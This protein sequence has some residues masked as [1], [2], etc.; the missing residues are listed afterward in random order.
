MI[1]PARLAAYDILMAVSAGRADLPTALAARRAR[2]ADDRDRALASEIAQD[3]AVNTEYIL[4]WQDRDGDKSVPPYTCEQ[5]KA[6]FIPTPDGYQANEW[7]GFFAL[8]RN[9]RHDHIDQHPRFMT[10]LAEGRKLISEL[11]NP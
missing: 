10:W 1:S 7:S 5:V 11:L 9:A 4:N 6:H 2:L 8:L 3:T